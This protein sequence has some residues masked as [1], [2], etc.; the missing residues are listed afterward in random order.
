[1][2]VCQTRQQILYREVEGA[3]T[4]RDSYSVE[5]YRCSKCD[6]WMCSMCC[7]NGVAFEFHKMTCLGASGTQ[8]SRVTTGKV[9]KTKATRKN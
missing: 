5:M 6:P 8:P 1:M 2:K 4:V 3:W 7:K 9:R